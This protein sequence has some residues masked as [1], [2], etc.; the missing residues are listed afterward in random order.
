MLQLLRLEENYYNFSPTLFGRA[1]HL[2]NVSYH[3]D[4]HASY[5]VYYCLDGV[6]TLILNGKTLILR[7]GEAVL[8]PSYCLHASVSKTQSEAYDFIFSPQ[9]VPH[10]DQWFKNKTTGEP[11]WRYDPSAVDLVR[12]MLIDRK[13][14]DA[15]HFTAGVNLLLC[16]FID[17]NAFVEKDDKQT[18]A[19]LTDALQYID[20]AFRQRLT[21]E[22]VAKGINVSKNYLSKKINEAGFSFPQL[23]KFF[24][25]SHA[26]QL[27]VAGSDSVTSIAF[28]SG[29][30]NIKTFYIDFKAH[31]GCSPLEFRKKS[32]ATSLLPVPPI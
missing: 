22:T 11:V 20:G 6:I 16:D 24:R 31:N 12:K 28:A 17:A 15:V 23:L 2:K 18:S 27:L 32:L 19:I 7:K 10:F 26:E 4:I 13:A 25:L 3:P 14:P 1:K 30:S 8:L 29:Y 9:S 5:E 21:L